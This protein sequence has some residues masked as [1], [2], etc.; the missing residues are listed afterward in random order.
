M[1]QGGALDRWVAIGLSSGI[2]PESASGITVGAYDLALWRGADGKARVWENRCPHRGMRLSYGFVRENRLSCIYH[3]WSYDGDGS[4]AA[5]PAHPGL[6]P[7]KTIKTQIFECVE[8]ADMIWAAVKGT[9]DP[10]PAIPGDWTGCRS[11]A[12][13]A[14]FDTVAGL[15]TQVDFQLTL[16]A[17]NGAAGPL[18]CELQ[19]LGDGVYLIRPDDVRTCDAL[20]CAVQPV[21]T[22]KVMLHVSALL[23]GATGELGENLKLISN[24]A[25]SLR[26][27]AEAETSSAAA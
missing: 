26:R 23:T 4:C 2:A 5:I 19:T 6:T 17:G 18:T 8:Q 25:I 10:E 3:G 14:P 11:I 16:P 27:M 21:A 22:C 15:F 13:D 7:P 1:A 24:W 9:D 12:I 20:L